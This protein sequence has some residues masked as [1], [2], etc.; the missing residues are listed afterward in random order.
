MPRGSV[1]EFLRKR[2]YVLLREL[3]RGGCGATVLLEDPTIGLHVV[4]KK[5]QPMYGD[6]AGEL[7]ERFV[8]EVRVLYR[9][10]HPNVVRVYNHYIYPESRAGYVL[11]E[12][13]DGAEIHEFVGRDP[14]Q[15][16]ALFEQAVDAFAYLEEQRVLHRDIRMR[17]LMVD[18]AGLLKV[19][20]FGFAK[21]VEGSD[22]YEK[23]MTLN[24]RFEV[25]EDFR[26][27]RYDFTT[28]VYFVGKLFDELVADY[29]G[30]K[31]RHLD[32]L[33]RMCRPDRAT[34]ISSFAKCR[35]AMG[36]DRH[37]YETM[38]DSD[39]EI[40]RDFAEEVFSAVTEVRSDAHFRPHGTILPALETTLARV[41][42]EKRV[43]NPSVVA[44]CLIG[45]A[46]RYKSTANVFVE[47]LK[48][49]ID[50]LRRSNPERRTAIF[51]NLECRFDTKSRYDEIPY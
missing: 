44:S 17:N 29:P 16:A 23:S 21:A 18:R 51:T 41:S 37:G 28:E 25:P 42:L 33:A 1:V 48:D 46:Y 27:E 24:W 49:F 6:H 15:L 12:Y 5:Y 45:G 38:D 30:S 35:E 3:G 39:L 8:G 11:M 31:F 32:L 14:G 22:D 43:P 36:T 34:R 2:D 20:D 40:Y 26:T 47:T 7:F 13:I 50:L 19:I 9:L 10:S 4:C